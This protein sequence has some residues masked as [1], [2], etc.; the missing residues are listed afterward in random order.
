M[1]ITVNELANAF[2]EWDRRYREDPEGFMSE[3]SHLLL[4]TPESY[5]EEVA[6]YF[7]KILKDLKSDASAKAE[8]VG[9]GRVEW[10]NGYSI[11]YNQGYKI[12]RKWK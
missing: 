5:G 11:G 10:S 6:P 4:D 2:T 7:V 1:E 9:V 3:G 8:F 12:G